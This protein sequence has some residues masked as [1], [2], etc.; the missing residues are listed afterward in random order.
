MVEIGSASPAYGPAQ[1]EKGL[2]YY[3]GFLRRQRWTIAL[4]ALAIITLATLAAVLLPAEFQ[5]RATILIE[6][7]EVSQDYVRS[8]SSGYAAQQVQVISQRVLTLDTITEI[9][10]KYHL[11][12]DEDSDSRRPTMALARTFRRNMSLDLVS[13]DIIDPR[14]RPSEATIAFTLA[15]LGP[16]PEITRQITSDLVELFLNENRRNR[17][18]QAN[19]TAEF[20]AKEA[21]QLKDEMNQ[22]ESQLADFKQAHDGSLPEQYKFNLGILERAQRE[23]YDLDSRLKVLRDN[24]VELKAEMSQLSP[25]APVVLPSGEVVL[26]DRERLRALQTEYRRASAIYRDN[27]PDVIRLKREIATLQ[28]E[29]GVSVDV[30]DLQR[31]LYEQR[32]RLEELRSRYNDNYH[33]VQS[34]Q[35]VLAQIERS[36][37]AARADSD[38]ASTEPVADNPAYIL[39]RSKVSAIDSELRTTQVKRRE[40]ETRIERYEKLLSRAPQVERDYNALRLE[41]ANVAEK[42]SDI[43]SKQREAEAASAVEL[44]QKGQRFSLIE[45]PVLPTDPVSP[46]R[47]AILFLGVVLGAGVGIGLALLRD[48]LGG[49]IHGVSALSA[50]MGFAPLVAIPYIEVTRGGVTPLRLAAMLLLALLLASVVGGWL[51]HQFVAPLDKILPNQIM[52]VL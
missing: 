1:A 32:S 40:L 16:T 13:A 20:L 2:H 3:L 46:N 26:S 18:D 35:R 38:T 12:Q 9:V 17:T 24:R 39:L 7:Q 11:Y 45:P 28:N 27:H 14:G 25:T 19:S 5:A 6:E 8:V 50:E 41:H 21:A 29:M 23:L 47:P 15:F 42:Y 33:A 31:Q 30:Q 22:L 10:N 37:A 36:I 44:E 43:R 52:D 4:P 34:A 49:R 48:T 51:V